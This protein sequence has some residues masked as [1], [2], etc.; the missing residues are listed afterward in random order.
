MKYGKW[1][2]GGLGWALGGPLGGILGFALGS[3]VDSADK[4]STNSTHSRTQNHNSFASSLLVLIAA[5]LKADEKIMQSELDYIKR[6]F[7]R[8]FGEEAA[9]EA[10]LLLRDILKRPIPLYEVCTQIRLN[11]DIAARREL[12]HLLFGVALADGA[13]DKREIA[14]IQVIATNLGLSPADFQSIKAMFA[15]NEDHD[16]AY[17]V[18]EINKNATNE[19]VKKAYRSMAQKH[20]PDKVAQMGEDIQRAANEKFTKIKEAH[21]WI[22]KSRGIA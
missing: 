14:V 7:V 4:T 18:L 8:Q 9:K 17:K 22:K 15:Q 2:G 20:H 6:F 1:L 10:I 21:E 13:L 12:L 3:L 19:E 16:W 5:V 11:L